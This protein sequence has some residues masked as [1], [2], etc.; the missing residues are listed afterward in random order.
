MVTKLSER[1]Q[2]KLDTSDLDRKAFVREMGYK[3]TTKGLRRLDQ[4]RNGED[5]PESRDQIER[6]SR[7]IPGAPEELRKL[8]EWEQQK[9]KLE[10]LEERRN[11][12]RSFLV[13]QTSKFTS[14]TRTYSGDRA[15][16]QIKKEAR[17]DVVDV[18]ENLPNG[19]TDKFLGILN[20]PECRNYLIDEEGNVTGVE[21]DAVSPGGPALWVQ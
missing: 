21:E 16:E 17:N 1:I 18:C 7:V 8:I 12:P 19:P 20:T 3:N 10:R 4:W 2:N 14:K 15:L 5:W 6:L 9:Q 13:V 11:D